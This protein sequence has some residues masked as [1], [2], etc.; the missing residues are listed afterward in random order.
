[1]TLIHTQRNFLTDDPTES[2]LS[3]V[4]DLNHGGFSQGVARAA[5]L[6]GGQLTGG[7]G[8]VFGGILG[9][10]GLFGITLRIEDNVGDRYPIITEVVDLTDSNV[11]FQI[12]PVVQ[13]NIPRGCRVWVD[14]ST[15]GPI[16]VYWYL[17]T[18]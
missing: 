1:M 12:D 6:Y 15:G 4:R 10:S 2:N 8:K 17:I 11:R 7:Q 9:A 14:I 18:S 5:G 3:H 16:T 13:G